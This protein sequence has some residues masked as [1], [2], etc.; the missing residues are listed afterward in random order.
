M[1]ALADAIVVGFVCYIHAYRR[2]AF[3]PFFRSRGHGGIARRGV[4]ELGTGFKAHIQQTQDVYF[5]ARRSVTVH[6]YTRIF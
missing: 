5:A 4:S 1:W 2:E 3:L 6:Q